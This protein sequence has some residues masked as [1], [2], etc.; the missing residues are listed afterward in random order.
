M[1]IQNIYNFIVLLM[2]REKRGHRREVAR[3]QLHVSSPPC[4]SPLYTFSPLPEPPCHLKVMWTWDD[5]R[6]V[7]AR[8]AQG[9]GS[10]AV[11]VAWPCDGWCPL[12]EGAEDCERWS[13]PVEGFSVASPIWL[14]SPHPLSIHHSLRMEPA[15]RPLSLPGRGKKKQQPVV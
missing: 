8:R 1:L 12:G 4:E 2:D 3:G 9:H 6:A 14:S 10:T 7:A 15:T 5:S 13:S 11:W